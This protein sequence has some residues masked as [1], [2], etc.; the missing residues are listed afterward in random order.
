MK[1]EN[2]KPNPPSSYYTPAKTHRINRPIDITPLSCQIPLFS[3]KN[4]MNRGKNT[5]KG[6]PF[7]P[8]GI[9]EKEQTHGNS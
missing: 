2:A 6:I 7:N 9:T 3:D 4:T 1:K 5:A 8:K